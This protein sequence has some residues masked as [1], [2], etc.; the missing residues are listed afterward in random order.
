M[1]ERIK[2]KCDLL[3]ENY[4]VV[5]SSAKLDFAQ[6]AAL[7]A[8]IYTG[9]NAN[10][11][12]QD[13]RNNRKLLHSKVSAFSNLVGHTNVALLCKMSLSDDPEAYLDKV[14]SAYSNLKRGIF[15][16]EYEAL[17]ASCIAD[18]A[19]PSRYEEIG[20]KAVEIL[21]KMSE[22][23]PWLTGAEDS[24]IAAML[25]M[26]GLDIDAT[27]AEAEECYKEIK[28]ARFTL[29]KDALQAVSMILALNSKSKEEKCEYFNRLRNELSN[30][31]SEIFGDQLPI[32][33]AFVNVN[34]STE[35]IAADIDEANRYLKEKSGFGD[36]FGIGYKMRVTLAAAVVLQAY[37]DEAGECAI[38]EAANNAMASIIAQQIVIDI[39][40]TMIIIAVVVSSSSNH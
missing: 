14:I 21:D 11:V 30:T 32:L 5:Q 22:L 12:E 3:A 35:Q 9:K 37:Q 28:N 17:A 33:A 15:H 26:T 34:E 39:V 16:S 4:N 8:L 1:N 24:S 19:D 6:A 18:N 2:A 20:Q 25:A 10:A 23:H 27:L 36:W 40:M 13:I 38:A 7:G 31:K 29:S